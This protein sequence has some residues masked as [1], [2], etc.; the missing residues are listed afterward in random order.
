MRSPLRLLALTLV[1]SLAAVG[2][3]QAVM[4]DLPEFTLCAVHQGAEGGG[5]PR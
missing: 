5:Q 4:Q 1:V 3:A 2:S